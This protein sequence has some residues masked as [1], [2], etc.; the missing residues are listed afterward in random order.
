MI[1]ALTASAFYYLITFHPNSPVKPFEFDGPF[2]RKECAEL[3]RYV[4]TG[5]CW[6]PLE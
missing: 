2:T 6:R 5:R 4:P 3:Q 1:L